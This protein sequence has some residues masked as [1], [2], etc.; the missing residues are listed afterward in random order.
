MSDLKDQKSEVVAIGETHPEAHEKIAGRVLSVWKDLR[1]RERL[2]WWK[3]KSGAPAVVMRQI[4][5]LDG[6]E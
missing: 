1:K 5:R 4:P 3:E 6:R 2:W